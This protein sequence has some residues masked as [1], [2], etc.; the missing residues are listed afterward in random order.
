MSCQI[1]NNEENMQK[2]SLKSLHNIFSI[3]TP[4][5][6]KYLKQFKILNFDTKQQ[7]QNTE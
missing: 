5:Q 1:P 4:V 3:D 2:Y 6:Y 7:Q